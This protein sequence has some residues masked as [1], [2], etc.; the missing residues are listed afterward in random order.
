MQKNSN[1]LTLISQY[2]YIY[3]YFYFQEMYKK[4]K[5]EKEIQDYLESLVDLQ[6]EKEMYE[7]QD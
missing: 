2:D 4:Y 7:Y 1:Q 5:R 3:E 6:I